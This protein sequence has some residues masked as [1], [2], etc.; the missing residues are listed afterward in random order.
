MSYPGKKHTQVITRNAALST[1]PETSQIVPSSSGLPRL[2]S[3]L[4]FGSGMYFNVLSK[5]SKLKV[6]LN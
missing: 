3:L 5:Y 1:N 2:E 6:Y 4:F